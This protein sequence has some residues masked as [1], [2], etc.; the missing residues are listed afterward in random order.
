MPT[1][2]CTN[3]Q[4]TRIPCLKCGQWMGLTL[5]EP[6]GRPNFELRTYACI[7]CETGESFLMAIK[8]A[9]SGEPHRQKSAPSSV[10]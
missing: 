3:F 5:I 8:P 6:G 9:E 1:P 10:S 7:P 4:T 2:T